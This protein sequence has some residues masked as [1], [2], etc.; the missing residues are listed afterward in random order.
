MLVPG[1]HGFLMWMVMN[2]KS[3]LLLVLALPLSGQ[4][5]AGSLE[6]LVGA[7]LGHNLGLET[8]RL[9]TQ[10]ANADLGTAEGTFDP[11][12]TV[13]SQ[14]TRNQETAVLTDASRSLGTSGSDSYTAGL[15][16]ATPWSTQYSLG[17]Q[18]QSSLENPVVF[19]SY[20]SAWN[21]SVVLG[22]Q[23][24]LLRGRGPAVAGAPV[25]RARYALSAA[26]FQALE[27]ADQ[28]VA[29]VE[30]AFAAYEWAGAQER[31]SEGALQRALAARDKNRHLNALGLMARIDLVTAE[32]TV[33]TRRS[34]LL[35]ARQS[36]QDAGDAL[37]AM[38]YGATAGPALQAGLP[39]EVPAA[40]Q[41]RDPGPLPDLASCET[42][43]LAQRRVVGANRQDLAALQVDQRVARDSLKP[44]LALTGSYAVQGLRTGTARLAAGPR[45]GDEGLQGWTVGLSL[46]VPVFNRTARAAATRAAVLVRQQELQLQQVE[47]TVRTDVRKAYRAIGASRERLALDEQAEE[48]S[49]SRFEGEYQRLDLGL[50]DFFRVNQVEEELAVAELDTAQA[51]YELEVAVSAFHLAEG[52]SAGAYL[53]GRGS[54]E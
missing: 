40:A 49:R 16:G 39:L 34:N 32:N 23:Q 12:V 7:A 50:T 20:P 26:E 15:A 24:P 8:I 48:L 31:L 9:A 4:A 54:A 44:A 11:Q 36:R 47:L 46:A 10:A 21:S 28:T 52:N 22:F 1:L 38:V 6:E 42:L 33:A 45:P 5:P 17:L 2:K 37:L 51:R 29:A 35:G 19:Q 30:Q 25:L 43:A 27:Q 53:G 18:T 3:M 13:A 41:L 14:W